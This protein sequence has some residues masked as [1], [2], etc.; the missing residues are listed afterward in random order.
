MRKIALLTAAAALFASAA[1]AANDEGPITAIDRE[2]MT[3]TL[4]NGNVYKLPG[5]FDIEAIS[6]GMDVLL[7][8]EE[9]EGEKQITDMDVGN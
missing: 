4:E 1:L 6:E 7:A 2:A 9:I 5:E 8:Y 3:I